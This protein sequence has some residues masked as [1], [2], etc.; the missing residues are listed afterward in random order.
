MACLFL[1]SLLSTVRPAVFFSGDGGLKYLVTQQRAGNV[2]SLQLSAEPWVNHLW[3]K[4]F[5]PFKPPFVYDQQGRKIVSFPPFFQL[6]TQ[7]F[8]RMGQSA[9]LYIIPAISLLLLW[10]WFARLL[11]RLKVKHAIAAT[12]LFSMAFCSPLTPYGAIYWEHTLAVLWL[13][14]G[15]VFLVNPYGSPLRSW[16]LGCLTGL[17]AW[18]RPEALLL[19]VLIICLVLYNQIRQPRKNNAYFVVGSFLL[20]ALFF[21]CNNILYGNALGAHSYQLSSNASVSG[22]FMQSMILL[23]HLNGKQLLFFPLLLITFGAAVHSLI[24]KHTLP[25]EVIQLLIIALSFSLIAPFFLP[26]GGGKQW[27]PRYF[28]FL[29]PIILVAGAILANTSPYN[30]I[31]SLWLLIPVLVYSICLNSFSAYKT[32][33][34]DYAYR[35]QPCLQLLQQDSCNILVVQNQFVAQEFAALFRTKHIFLAENRQQYAKLQSLL[36][37]AGKQEWIFLAR[38]RELVLPC[39]MQKAP[40]PVLHAG[41]YFFVRC[42]R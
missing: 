29:V 4:G 26:N 2:V 6:L 1:V 15:I 22:R 14:A 12:A 31:T 42:S 40:A 32:L 35:V 18:L 11:N 8:F 30:K 24:K 9:G 20:V 3:D 34:N 7:P 37:A 28:L 13:F 19:W 21:V 10:L 23:T 17:A 38:D 27:G 25:T 5:Y 16:V 36:L 33:R 39:S 41:D